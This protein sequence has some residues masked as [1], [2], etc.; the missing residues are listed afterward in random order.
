M[1]DFEKFEVYK[2]SKK[3]NFEIYTYLLSIKKVDSCY[4]DQ[5]K[6]ASLSIML[7]IAEGNSRFT[8]ADKRRFLVISRGS[9]FECAAIID[10]L[11]CQK[12]I[13]PKLSECFI[14]SL[15]SISTTLFFMIKK[16][17]VK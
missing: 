8:K 14:K 2:N 16:L 7:N 6:R 11:N 9:V 3:L 15:E 13:D 17:E 1:F 5:L 12:L 4:R 10:F